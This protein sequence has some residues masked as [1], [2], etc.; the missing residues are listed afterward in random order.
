ML[1][2]EDYELMVIESGEVYQ[3][4]AVEMLL[5]SAV[6]VPLSVRQDTSGMLVLSFMAKTPRQTDRERLE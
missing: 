2:Q 4:L 6:A 1:G 5:L 3:D